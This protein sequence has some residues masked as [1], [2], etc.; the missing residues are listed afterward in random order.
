MKADLAMDELT[1]SRKSTE[2][3]KCSSLLLRAVIPLA[4]RTR[5]GP[6]L[7]VFEGSRFPRVVAVPPFFGGAGRSRGICIRLT[8]D[9]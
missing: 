5:E 3:K 1:S 6:A 8:K 9:L 2:S 7:S 4:L